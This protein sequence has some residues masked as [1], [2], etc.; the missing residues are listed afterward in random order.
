LYTQKK[1]SEVF[2]LFAV[3]TSY[4]VGLSFFTNILHYRYLFL[5][6]PCL[7]ILAA[8]GSFSLYEAMVTVKSYRSRIILFTL[9]FVSGVS[10]VVLTPEWGGAT[11]RQSSFYALESD[12]VDKKSNTEY[13]AYT[14]QPD[15]AAAY[16]AIQASSTSE[17][18]I[19]SSH[20]HFTYLF[21]GTPGYWIPVDYIDTDDSAPLQKID[22]YVG[23]LPVDSL[24]GLITFTSTH[25][26]FIVFD[27]QASNDRIPEDMLVYIRNNYTL[28]YE[29]NTN[30]YSHIWVYAF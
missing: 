29:K 30:P 11:L 6:T 8:F 18:V 13:Y 5:V 19:I 1:R 25:R 17:S 14:P 10:Y 2:L 26:G 22:P 15:W 9:L 12:S 16:A 21:T 7:Y 20:P 23:A 24:D 27:Y 3:F 28:M 4:L